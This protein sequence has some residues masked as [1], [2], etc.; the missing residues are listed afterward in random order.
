MG[1]K[2]SSEKQ[3]GGDSIPTIEK[4]K[5]ANN[6][7]VSSHTSSNINNSSIGT[8]TQ[9]KKQNSTHSETKLSNTSTI[10]TN[11]S[12]QQQKGEFSIDFIFH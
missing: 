7:N 12:S 8:S 9:T 1:S 5:N 10:T 3:K 2:P 6:S 4:I 11:I